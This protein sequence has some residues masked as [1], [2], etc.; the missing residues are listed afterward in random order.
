MVDSPDNFAALLPHESIVLELQLAEAT[1]A[2]GPT[3]RAPNS[4]KQA[5]ATSFCHQHGQETSSGATTSS[6]RCEVFLSVVWCGRCTCSSAH[7]Y[8][9]CSSTRPHRHILPL[10]LKWRSKYGHFQYG[11]QAAP[12]S[13]GHQWL[14][15][16]HSSFFLPWC[17][18]NPT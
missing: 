8:R 3:C 9:V 12:S 10:Q 17:F 2:V 6:D 1:T 13:I 16:S 7:R 15:L 14:W 4:H 5:G 18:T 11:E